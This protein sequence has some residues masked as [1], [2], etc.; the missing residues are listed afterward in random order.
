MVSDNAYYEENKA[1]LVTQNLATWPD[2]AIAGTGQCKL[3]MTATKNPV[4]EKGDVTLY[5]N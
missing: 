1:A 5:C 4:M 3:Q 2:R